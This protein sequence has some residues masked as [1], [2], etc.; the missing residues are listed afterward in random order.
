MTYICDILRDKN[1]L[2][3]Q[4]LTTL[5]GL[6]INNVTKQSMRCFTFKIMIE[7]VVLSSIVAVAERFC[8]YIIMLHSISHL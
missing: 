6:H 3:A 2:K 7:N 8:S 1:I 5:T 4:L